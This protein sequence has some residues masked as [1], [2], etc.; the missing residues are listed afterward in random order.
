M[1]CNKPITAW[2]E[3]E[4]GKLK[5]T[6]D[7]STYGR[8]ITMTV[9]CRKCM[10]C[11]LDQARDWAVRMYHEAQLHEENSFVTLTYNDANL[12]R[13]GSLQYADVQKFLKR[14]RKQGSNFRYYCAPEYG[15][16]TGRP[17]Y[18]LCL[19]GEAFTEDRYQWNKRGERWY[20][21]S[22]TLEKAWPYGFCDLSDFSYGAAQYVSKYVTKKRTGDQAIERYS[23][24]DPET[25]E[26]VHIEHEQARMSLNPAIG[27]NWFAKYYK[28]LFPA[29]SVV[30][31]GKHKPMPEY[32][33]KLWK[34]ICPTGMEFIKR[35][36]RKDAAKRD[37]SREYQDK[38]EAFH[39]VQSA[40]KPRDLRK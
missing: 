28:E 12:P 18:H 16:G 25:G 21:R 8:D 6:P 9:S 31:D 33:D 22:P 34:T 3:R 32:Y 4:T 24:I 20:Y 30:I 35:Q 7:E 2:K 39:K 29:D 5:F 1:A 14:L 13:Y 10:G 17:H 36:R 11:R 40:R 27:F 23:K 37:N 15:D 26:L 38:R 19:F